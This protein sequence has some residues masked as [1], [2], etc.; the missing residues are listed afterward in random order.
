ML[1]A[2]LRTASVIVLL[3]GTACSFGSAPKI[4]GQSSGGNSRSKKVV[5]AGTSDADARRVSTA[6]GDVR[7]RDA[8]ADADTR[9]AAASAAQGGK[10]GKAGAGGAGGKR[11]ASMNEGGAGGAKPADEQDTPAENENEN[12]S[13]P[14]SDEQEPDPNEAE[15]QQPPEPAATD[16]GNTSATDAGMQVPPTDAA[17]GDAGPRPTVDNPFGVLGDLA[18]R[19]AGGKTA[20][21]INQ[22]LETLAQGEAPATSIREFLTAIDDEIDC[23]MNPFAT[24]CLAAC[25]AVS[26]TCAVCVFDEMCRMTMLEICGYSALAGCVPRR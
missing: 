25:Q 6:S 19:T 11:S 13:T 14:P 24:E 5:D 9:D 26:T 21:T 12:E 10:G 17:V 22:F 3:S 2:L 8:E 20:A 16:A 4:G 1:N 15:N 18:N 7:A 23:V